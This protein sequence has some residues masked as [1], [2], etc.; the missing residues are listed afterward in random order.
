MET[1]SMGWSALR[2]RVHADFFMRSRLGE[3]RRLLEQATSEGYRF[4]SLRR[5]LEMHQRGERPGSRYILL[6]HD[7]DTG[8]RT[9]RAM[10]SIEQML[11]INGSYYFRLRTVSPRFMKAIE[12]RG[13]EASYHFEE[14][15][16][17]A[18]NRRIQTREE[19]LSVLR[20]ARDL[21]ARNLLDLRKRTG[22]RME[23]VASHGDWIN[24]KLGV[25][26]SEILASSAFRT[27]VGVELE[28]YDRTVMD[29][30]LKHSDGPPPRRW[31]WEDRD[32]AD[33]IRSG[34]AAMQI[35]VHPRHWR[36]E[37]FENLIDN[38]TRCA[39]ALRHRWIQ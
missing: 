26:N 32:P 18:K 39:E 15:S 35:L 7:V 25:Q 27:V 10:W 31:L 24:R 16:T 6:R 21:F 14:L 23:V 20:D 19:A 5:F 8:V 11:G 2:R 30:V 22:L 12:E 36:A 29:V 3:Y 4:C 13:G 28:A 37:P 17:L 1:Y 9:A 34:V 33:S 38:A